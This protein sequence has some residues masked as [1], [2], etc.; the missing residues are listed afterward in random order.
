MSHT[1]RGFDYMK[2]LTY[3]CEKHGV[4]FG[5]LTNRLLEKKE[6]SEVSRGTTGANN[7]HSS[8]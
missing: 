5:V 2:M 8:L 3:V 7:E 1:P 6:G 4:S